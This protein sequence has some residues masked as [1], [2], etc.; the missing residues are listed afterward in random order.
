LKQ[1]EILYSSLG[2]YLDYPRPITVKMDLNKKTGPF[3]NLE[4]FTLSRLFY[5]QALRI[6][7]HAVLPTAFV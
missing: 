2:A 7:K 3:K 5:C 6:V 1:I 4:N